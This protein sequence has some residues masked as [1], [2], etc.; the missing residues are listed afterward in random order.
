VNLLEAKDAKG[1]NA[2]HFAAA[3]GHLEAC[4]FLVEESG[5]DVN[6]TTPHGACAT[7]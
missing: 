1:R 3:N 6:S 2:L 4:M 5:F 7:S